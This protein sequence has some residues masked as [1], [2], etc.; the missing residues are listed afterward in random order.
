M[1]KKYSRKKQYTKIKSHIENKISLIPD[2]KADEYADMIKKC[3]IAQ[4]ISLK[5]VLRFIE[6][7]E[8]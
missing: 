1:F 2:D 4:K 8:S 5:E 3:Y 6:N 7:E